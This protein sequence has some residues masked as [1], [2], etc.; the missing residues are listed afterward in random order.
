[1]RDRVIWTRHVHG[2]PA[3][4]KW[5]ESIPAGRTVQLRVAGMSGVWEKMRDRPSGDPTPGL[6]PVGKMADYWRELFRKR[7][8][9]LVELAGEG[10]SSP[11]IEEAPGRAER[12][13]AWAAF[14][15]LADRG[16]RS[17]GPYGPR[18]ELYDRKPRD[19]HDC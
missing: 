19:A 3:L 13:A 15:D 11:L 10:P 14:L 12:D 2:E 17:E 16:W 8:G 7:R 18:E 1:M 9:E 6:K 5:L 4:V